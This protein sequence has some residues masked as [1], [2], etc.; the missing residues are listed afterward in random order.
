[1]GLITGESHLGEVV[2]EMVKRTPRILDNVSG[3][4]QYVERENGE[5]AARQ[6]HLSRLLIALHSIYIQLRAPEG[7]GILLQLRGVFWP[8]RPSPE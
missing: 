7:S 6:T 1:M 4:R 3:G 5:R 2:G 8:V